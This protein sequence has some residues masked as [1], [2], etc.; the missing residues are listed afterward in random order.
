ML[1]LDI[2]TMNGKA[3][4]DILLHHLSSCVAKAAATATD[5]AYLVNIVGVRGEVGIKHGADIQAQEDQSRRC[6]SQLPERDSLPLRTRPCAS[7]RH[8]P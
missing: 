5:V 8:P 3:L 7:K 4:P 1:L 6:Q 2:S